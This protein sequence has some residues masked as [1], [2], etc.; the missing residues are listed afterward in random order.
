MGKLLRLAAATALGLT[1]VGGAAKA[2]AL[3]GV[4]KTESGEQTQSYACG[5]SICI[6]ILTGK[7]KGEVIAD[8]LANDG[9]GTYS[10]SIRDPADDKVYSGSATLAD[11]KTLKLKGCALKI[12]C[13]TQTWVRLK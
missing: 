12:F 13:K 2:E 5:G 3:E 7:F 4:W 1:L 10:G 11:A 8:N 6:K 9:S